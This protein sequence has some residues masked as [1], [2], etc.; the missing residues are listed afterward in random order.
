[1]KKSLLILAAITLLG[2]A[3]LFV[4]CSEETAP[5][6]APATTDQVYVSGSG[7]VTLLAGQTIPA[8]TVCITVDNALNCV[9]VT[10]AT[11]NGWQLVEAHLWAGTSLTQ[12]PVNRSGNPVPGQFPYVSGNITGVT[13]WSYCIPLSV[14]NLDANMET[15]NQIGYFAAHAALQQV[16]ANGNVIQTQTG[17]GEGSRIVN[18]GS[19][20]TYYTMQF[21]CEPNTP[22]AA[23]T[24][25]TA[26]AFSGNDADCFLNYGF[27]RW[28]W[29]IGPLAPGSY[30]YDVYAA[31][32]QCDLSKG[33]NV[34]AVTV[35]Y[36]GAT[37]TV[38]YNMS[39]GFTMDET[40]VS[41]GANQ[42]PVMPNG[43]TSV[44]PGQYPSIHDGLAGVATDTHTIS[45]LSGNI[46]VIAHAMSCSNN[47]PQ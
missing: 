10:Y 19:W 44:A 24:C 30:T 26:F 25:E 9:N 12:M 35:N 29:V 11:V 15:C 23:E 32:G 20:A 14:F 1:M 33:W 41:A 22:P 42:F 27:E 38:T 21:F 5:V 8:G 39:T 6:V 4:G 7:C 37:A 34:G 28:G 13:T 2:M 43:H 36:D 18:R 3:A 31:A 47:W 40:Q 17:W 16:D 46:Y 45:G